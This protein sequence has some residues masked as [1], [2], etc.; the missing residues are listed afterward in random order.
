MK[1]D[2][3]QSQNLDHISKNPDDTLISEKMDQLSSSGKTDFAEFA[4]TSNFAFDN[5]PFVERHFSNDNHHT[6][7]A[8]PITAN[9]VFAAD[10]IDNYDKTWS[11]CF[12][13]EVPFNDKY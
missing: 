8:N 12:T 7:C 10:N 9:S 4:T 3:N 2:L 1:I 13:S 6:L 11:A 5:Q